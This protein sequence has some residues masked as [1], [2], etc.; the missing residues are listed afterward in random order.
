MGSKFT[1]IK[2]SLRHNS[3]INYSSTLCLLIGSGILEEGIYL[4]GKQADTRCPSSTSAGFKCPLTSINCMFIPLHIFHNWIGIKL[5]TVSFRK[6]L[7]NL[8]H[9]R[10]REKKQRYIVQQAH[11]QS[12]CTKVFCDIIIFF[13]TVNNRKNN[14]GNKQ[15]AEYTSLLYGSIEIWLFVVAAFRKAGQQ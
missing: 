6:R 12:G 1:C 13:R 7:P 3:L 5:D 11:E 15:R 2:S 10:I 4:G 14:R 9:Y 8:N